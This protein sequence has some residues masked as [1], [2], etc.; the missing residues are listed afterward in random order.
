[1]K[2]LHMPAVVGQRRQ[3]KLSVTV[4]LLAASFVTQICIHCLLF[5]A[6]FFILLTRR[7]ATE[8]LSRPAS[9]DAKILLPVEIF[10]LFF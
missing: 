6:L 7:K 10:Y 9:G 8:A 2:L 4:C 3:F 1:M 5:P